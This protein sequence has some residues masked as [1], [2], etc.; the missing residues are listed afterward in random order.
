M[1]CLE[2]ADTQTP[3]SCLLYVQRLKL[4]TE[5]V[6]FTIAHRC[7]GKTE[8]CRTDQGSEFVNHKFGAVMRKFNC[9]HETSCAGDSPMNGSS[10][11]NIGIC[12][13]MIRVCLAAAKQPN[14]MWGEAM[15]YA[16][17]HH[18]YFPCYA[19]PDLMS[20][21]EMRTGKKPDLAR[22]HA[23]GELCFVLAPKS[24]HR[25][26]LQTRALPCMLIGYEDSLGT[27]AYAQGHVLR[28]QSRVRFTRCSLHGSHVQGG[29][30]NSRR[31]S[32]H[33]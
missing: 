8:V 22:L 1:V 12:W 14:R 10:E 23:F 4:R 5:M 15:N 24:E 18:D 2:S 6:E 28:S 21:N 29:W 9:R 17:K 3:G 25:A 19:N 33:R 7:N 32:A 31:L 30:P 11:R 27:K 16:E 26:K 20:P 13:Q